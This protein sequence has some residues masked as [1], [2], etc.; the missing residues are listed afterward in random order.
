[1]A[2]IT[3]LEPSILEAVCR[4]IGGTENGLTG[5][6]IERLLSQ[7]RIEDPGPITKWQRLHQ[8]LGKR[9]HLDNCGNLY[10]SRTEPR[11]QP[12]HPPLV[13]RSVHRHFA[14]R[15]SSGLTV[16]PDGTIV[17]RGVARTLDEAEQ[18]ATLLRRALQ[19][20]KVH[21]EVLRY[22][23]AE[24]VADNY[25]H[26]VLEATKGVAARLRDLTGLLGDGSE[27]AEKALMLGQ[28]GH[29]RLAVNSCSSESEK[30]EQKGLA[31]L[32]KGLFGA[33]RNPT[34]HDPKIS[35]QMEE[36]DALDVL[37]TISYVH[38]RLDRAIR[39]H[40]P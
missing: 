25:F 17:R 34:A 11:L 15:H 30:S 27:L 8:A 32:V 19:G 36:Q 21:A 7:F 24:L 5:T 4:I 2:A 40:V 31:W 3:I 37:S 28:A 39:T 1:M 6:E 13:V 18:R 10:N 38:R 14:T 29:P 23:K 20:R 9:Q 12:V 26:A 35:W 22:C 16:E 33:F